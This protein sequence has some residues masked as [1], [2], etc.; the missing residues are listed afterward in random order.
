MSVGRDPGGEDLGVEGDAGGRGGA[1]GDPDVDGRGGQVH[2][3]PGATGGP[4]VSDADRGRVFDL[5]AWDGGDGAC[6][7]GEGSGG[8][9]AGGG[10]D[11]ADLQAR[12]DGRGDVE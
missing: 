12:R 11:P 3:D 8:G 10:G 1:E 4:A 5:G 7:A 2:P 6:G 9:G